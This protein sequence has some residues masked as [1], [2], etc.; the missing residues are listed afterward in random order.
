MFDRET[1]QEILNQLPGHV[2]EPRLLLVG[3]GGAGINMLRTVDA[4]A[5]LELVAVD[6]DDY[7][8]ALSGVQDQLYLPTPGDGGTGGDP[9]LG[10]AT[11][12]SHRDEIQELLGGDIL[13]LM[14]GLG[15]G[16]G[17][18][19]A[20]VV[21]ELARG[22]GLP[23]LALLVWPFRREDLA[24]TAGKGLHAIRAFADGLLVL[25]NEAARDLPGIEARSDAAQRVNEMI[26]R[27]LLDLGDRV[28]GAFPFSVR[29]EMADFLASLP[30]G[31]ANFPVRATAW[32]NGKHAEPLS[33]DP[34]G[35]VEFR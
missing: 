16:T 13:F 34:R 9:A 24:E 22:R 19:V 2:E 20:P 30:R 21:A 1:A 26:G 6:T 32:S 10:R 14:A 5:G 29:E 4:G 11:A 23:V 35:I 12:L 28:H 7:A 33:I 25:D 27:V 18:G 15:R 3:V 8:L 17:T 31:D